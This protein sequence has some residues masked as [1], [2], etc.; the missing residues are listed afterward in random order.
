M[1]N[2]QII[3]RFKLHGEDILIECFIND[4]F[5]GYYIVD[6]N[7]EFTVLNEKYFPFLRNKNEN[8]K[9]VLIWKLN[10][11]CIKLENIYMELC[12]LSRFEWNTTP[13]YGVL[14]TDFF[15]A[16]PLF[17]INQREKLLILQKRCK[18]KLT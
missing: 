8:N 4:S 11:H 15:K 14:G 9:K 3:L 13:I 10:S 6:F 2:N 1:I 18:R 12:D 17:E 7:L 5:K 16:Y